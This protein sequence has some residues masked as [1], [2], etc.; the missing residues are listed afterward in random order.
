MLYIRRFNSVFEEVYTAYNKK[1]RNS[2]EIFFAKVDFKDI[3]QYF[4]DIKVN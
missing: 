2:R 3:E 4:Q 1:Y